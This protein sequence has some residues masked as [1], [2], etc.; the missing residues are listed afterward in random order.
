[1]GLGR[2]P[3]LAR[4]ASRKLRLKIRGDDVYISIYPAA[5]AAAAAPARASNNADALTAYPQQPQQT[6]P[7]A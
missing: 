5:A 4:S 2:S 6:M 7:L 3:R 1:S